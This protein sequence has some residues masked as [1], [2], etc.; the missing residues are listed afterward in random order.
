MDA[1]K[2]CPFDAKTVNN[3]AQ[4]IIPDNTDF[5]SLQGC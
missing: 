1:L 3:I 5:T 4:V 2:D